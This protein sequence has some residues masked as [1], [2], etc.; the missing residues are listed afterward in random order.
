MNP[1]KTKMKPMMMLL[2]AAM[3][4][5]LFLCQAVM[6]GPVQLSHDNQ[7][8]A[9]IAPLWTVDAGNDTLITV[10]NNSANPAAIK[11]RLIGGDGFELL[12]FNLYLND[13]DSWAGALTAT[14]AGAALLFRDESCVLPVIDTAASGLAQIDLPL[15]ERRSGY[16][17]IFEMGTHDGPRVAGAPLPPWPSCADLAER[18]EAGDWA[19]DPATDMSA[20]QGRIST[21][22]QIIDVADG[23]M[24]SVPALAIDGFSDIAQHSAPDSAV[25]NLSTA[26]GEGTQFN[27]TESRRCGSAGC[28][29]LTWARP[30]EAVAS[31]LAKPALRGDVSVN[32]AI[33]ALAELVVTRPLKRY[34]AQDGF[35]LGSEAGFALLD[36]EGRFVESR[37]QTVQLSPPPPP[38]ATPIA[39]PALATDDAV[40]AVSFGQTDQSPFGVDSP[41]MGLPGDSISLD[42][43]EFVAG[44]G[45]ILFDQTFEQRLTSLE[46]QQ[47]RGEAAI[48]VVVLQI[49]NGTL[50]PDPTTQASVLSNYRAAE[51]MTPR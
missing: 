16:I 7:G 25:P 20:P 1:G 22:V 40:V 26:H 34:G 23:G 41:L 30:I 32:P 50:V 29:I 36:R 9:L 12:A 51:T 6:A 39:L 18:F 37:V 44:H 27:A 47:V 19:M 10:R 21:A 42:G 4:S 8:G 15:S 5:S 17:E 24:I 38:K 45:V 28:Q 49:S 43:T 33:G 13:D 14:D 2:R 11:V 31:I 46:D 48:G 3:C 35:A